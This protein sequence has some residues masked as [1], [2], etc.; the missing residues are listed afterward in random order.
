LEIFRNRE[1][2]ADLARPL[3]FSRRF[4][5]PHCMNAQGKTST[6]TLKGSS[7]CK[8]CGAPLPKSHETTQSPFCSE[9]C[10]M[11]DL[12]KWFG[13]N[14]RIASNPVPQSNGEEDGES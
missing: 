12:S 8:M 5:D 4:C 9:R 7:N 2:V 10:R 13:E 3:P 14:Y 11:N 6:N 1:V